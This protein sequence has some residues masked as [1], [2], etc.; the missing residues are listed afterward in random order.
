MILLK[1]FYDVLQSSPDTDAEG[2]WNSPWQQQYG[3]QDNNN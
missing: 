1:G 2:D 3:S